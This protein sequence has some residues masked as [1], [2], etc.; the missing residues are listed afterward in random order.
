MIGPVTTPEPS[1]QQAQTL[2]DVSQLEPVERTSVRFQSPQFPPAAAIE[3]YFKEARRIRWFSNRGPCY[4]LLRRRLE[5]FVGEPANAALV[6]SGTLGLMVALRACVGFA[7]RRRDVIVP[8]FTYIASV[9]AILWCGLEPVFVDVAPGHWHMDPDQLRVALEERHGA[10]A[11]VLACSTFGAAPP[12]QVRDS[13]EVICRDADVPLIVD[14]ASG[15]GSRD[16]HGQP[17]GLQGD[18]EVFSFH[19]TKP[20]VAGEGGALTSSDPDLVARAVRQSTF[21]L[22]ADRIL[23]EAPGLNAKMSE[24][25]AA[26]ALAAL[27]RF[28]G[29]LANR[30]SRAQ[31]IQRD[32]DQLGFEFQANSR[33]SASQFVP[34]LAPTARTRDAA[35][36]VARREGVELRTYHEPLHTME[37]LCGYRVVGDLETTVDLASRSLSLPLAVDLADASIERLRAVLWTATEIPSGSSR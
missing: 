16:E 1:P 24:L 13:W 7:P 31:H 5:G 18:V 32:L 10:V 27:D 37:P 17:L 20:L 30:Q 22:D 34:T 23:T 36:G 8:S 28:P 14:S 25:T 15:F 29:A 19:A 4:D 9:S 21:G 12:T 26:V 35:L 11:A 33:T 3:T 2:A 6:C